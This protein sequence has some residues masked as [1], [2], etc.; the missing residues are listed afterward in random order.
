MRSCSCSL[1]PL[2]RAIEK[3]FKVAAA[4]GQDAAIYRYPRNAETDARLFYFAIA[5]AELATRVWKSH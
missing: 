2:A 1:Q 3:R 5:H 4:K